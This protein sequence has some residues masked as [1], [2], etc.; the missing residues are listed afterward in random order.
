MRSMSL[1]KFI[2]TFFK[3]LKSELIWAKSFKSEENLKM[4]IFEFI[5]VWYNRKRIHSGLDY[6][7]PLEYELENTAA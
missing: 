4:E 5:E 1:I 7:S 6:M 2:E 3:T